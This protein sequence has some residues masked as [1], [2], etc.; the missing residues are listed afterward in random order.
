MTDDY[1]ICENCIA[2][3]ELRAELIERGKPVEICEICKIKGGRALSASDPLVKRIFRALVRLNF[4]EWD[5]NDHI[6]GDSIQSLVWQSKSIF[7]LGANASEEFFEQA[8]MI[9]EEG[10][11]PD[12]D[13][14]ITLGGG[15]WD[16]GVLSGLRD[17]RESSVEELIAACFAHNYFDVIPQ[18]K[19]LIEEL[20]DDITLLVPA[21][22]AYFR[23]RVGVKASYTKKSIWERKKFPYYATYTGSDIDKPPLTKASEGR[24]N[25]PRVSILYLASDVE[26]AVCELRPHPGHLISTASFK[27]TRDLRVANFGSHDI[28][29][30]LNDNRLEI[31]RKILSFADVLNLPVQPDQKELYAVTQTFADAIRESGF[32]AV[33]FRS[34]LGPGINMAC[35]ASGAFELIPESEHA[36]EVTSLSYRIIPARTLPATYNPDEFKEIKN[37]PFS[38][39][40]HGMARRPVA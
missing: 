28:R 37:D 6:G 29:N 14:G 34:S 12:T 32:D 39:V 4:S 11:Y 19:V 31:L 2:P 16:G 1:L 40:I 15:Y 35:F 26:T 20:R 8:L 3:N 7:N 36:H 24:L 9:M 17:E 25:R 23:G 18:A 33:T 30:Y 13:D 5:Y 21:G 22:A 38:T 27:A 10:W